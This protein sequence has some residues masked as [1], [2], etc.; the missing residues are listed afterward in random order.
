MEQDQLI[1]ELLDGETVRFLR[2][3]II[4]FLDETGQELFQDKKY[5]LFGLGGCGMSSGYYIDTI[6]PTW[7]SMKRRWFGGGESIFHASE[8]RNPTSK[9]VSVLATFF[10]DYEFLRVGA[11]ATDMTAINVAMPPFQIVAACLQQRI[12]RVLQGHPKFERIYLLFESS[13]RT[14]D[15]VQQYFSNFT[16]LETSDGREIP[17]IGCL[18]PKSL[19]EPGLEIADAIIHTSGA[20]TRNKLRNNQKSSYRQDYICVWQSI[21]AELVSF[22]EITKIEELR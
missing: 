18:V 5:P 11:I 7:I 17:V 1:L 8:L 16:M 20:Q 21:R 12:L 2:N 3:D 9:Q 19:A 10:T 15:Q 13:D 4:F 22:L 14:D 6:R